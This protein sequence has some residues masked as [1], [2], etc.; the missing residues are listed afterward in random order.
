VSESDE[1]PGVARIRDYLDHFARH[2]MEGLRD[3]FADDV[4]WHVGG[5]HPLSGDYRGKEALFEYF[6]RVHELTG[7]TLHLEA[8]SILASDL[9]VGMFTR[10]T[11]SHAGQELDVVL[12]QAFDVGPDG[13]WTQYYALANDQEAVDA[14]WTAIAPPAGEAG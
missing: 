11:A 4:V 1:H 5:A 9:H 13:R 10:V 12:S 6:E 8:T 2:D 3:F 7:G 14:F